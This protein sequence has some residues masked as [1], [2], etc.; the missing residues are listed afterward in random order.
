MY[1]ATFLTDN[2]KVIERFKENFTSYIKRCLNKTTIPGFDSLR[3]VHTIAELKNMENIIEHEGEVIAVSFENIG[4]VLSSITKM[5]DRAKKT[6]EVQIDSST[7]AII[8][9]KVENYPKSD[10][11]KQ[12]IRDTKD[13][14]T[15]EMEGLP[16]R[17]KPV[18]E[19]LKQ[20]IHE[21][22]GGM[23]TDSFEID[24]EQY[25]ILKNRSPLVNQLRKELDIKIE[26][27]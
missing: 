6:E 7:W 14:V 18:L 23:K 11:I 24:R 4:D 13:G 1:I 15:I 9:N 22:E 20:D 12:K 16:H 3:D 21:A 10:H 26:V 2:N 19:K 17:I 8:R 27:E 5:V 25:L